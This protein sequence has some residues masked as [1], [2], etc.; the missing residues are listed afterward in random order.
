M[1][2]HANVILLNGIKMPTEGLRQPSTAI[3]TFPS[4]PRVYKHVGLYVCSCTCYIVKTGICISL[5]RVKHLVVFYGD[6]PCLILR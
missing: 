2:L 6:S 4:Q 3:L 1:H 5:V